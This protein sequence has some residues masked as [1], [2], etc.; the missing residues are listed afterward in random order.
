MIYLS[1]DIYQAFYMLEL[2]PKVPTEFYLWLFY[3]FSCIYFCNLCSVAGEGHCVHYL[4]LLRFFV[5][6]VLI[7]LFLFY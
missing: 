2:K 3:F 6:D 5:V 7:V 1:V 4:V